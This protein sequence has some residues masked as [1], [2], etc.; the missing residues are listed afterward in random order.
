[1]KET[2]CEAQE[3]RVKYFRLLKPGETIAK[4]LYHSQLI[5]LKIAL[6]E[7]RLEHSPKHEWIVFNHVNA[8]H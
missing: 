1:M 3:Q 5:R 2:I 6:A 4:E 7:K 8:Q